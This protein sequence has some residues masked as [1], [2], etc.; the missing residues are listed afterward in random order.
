MTRALGNTPQEPAVSV[1]DALRDSQE[2]A[3]L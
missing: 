1:A 2:L 3:V